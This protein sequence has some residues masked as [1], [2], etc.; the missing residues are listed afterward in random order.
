MITS[1]QVSSLKIMANTTGAELVS[2]MKDGHEYIWQGDPK[3]WPR[4]APILFPIVGRLEKDVYR[5]GDSVYSLSQHGFARDCEFEM[6][7]RRSDY[8]Q[9]RL[10]SSEATLKKYPFQFELTV[11]YTLDGNKLLVV[12]IVKNTDRQMIWFSVGAH[13]GFCFEADETFSDYVLQFESREMA[14][15]HFLENGIFSGKSDRVLDNSDVLELSDRL[16][17][18]D[19]IILKNL[20]SNFVTIK[21][22]NGPR[23]IRVGFKG[24]PYLGIW[25]KPGAP[26]VCIEPWHGLADTQGSGK[27][28]REKEGIVSLEPDRTFDCHYDI[29]I[30]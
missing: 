2:V 29:V 20:K 3:I 10:R 17:E 15:R 19:A 27:D 5:I 30:E 8:L 1:I 14:D 4:H 21:N 11:H 23:S 6:V 7:G 28:F 9:F 16:F 12:Y 26:F 13:P 25:S 22:K 18:K 24:F